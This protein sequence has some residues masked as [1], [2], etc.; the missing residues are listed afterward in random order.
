MKRCCCIQGRG[1]G[2]VAVL[3]ALLSGVSVGLAQTTWTWVPPITTNQLNAVTSGQ[4][5]FVAVGEAGTVLTSPDGQSWTE[6][7]VGTNTWLLG[8]GYGSGTFVSVGYGGALYT[9]T[10]AYVW[11]EQRS[12]T[13]NWLLDVAYGNS[14][15]VAVGDRAVLTSPDAVAW[16]PRMPPAMGL[17]AQL[18]GVTYGDGRFVAVGTGGVFLTST[19]GTDWSSGV[20]LPTQPWLWDVAFGANQFVAVGEAGTI[21]TSTN[22]LA[23][24]PRNSGTNLILSGI[25]YGT[26]GFVAVGEGGTVLT[27]SNGRSWT[28]PES[29]TSLWLLGAAAKG[30]TVV[31]VGTSGATVAALPVEVPSLAIFAP[32][33]LSTGEFQCQVRGARPGQPLTFWARDDLAALPPHWTAVTNQIAGGDPAVFV[34]PGAGDRRVRSYQV[35]TP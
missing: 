7:S 28:S 10:N 23:W 20:A 24:V 2:W 15:F 25:T 13:T 1:S 8:V 21:L 3:A 18:E 29:T 27:S 4:D 9:S 33:M 30:E 17:N 14:L 11:T 16:T 12:G 5:L 26:N 32:Q 34:D 6:G 19:N 22:G 35:S 31:A